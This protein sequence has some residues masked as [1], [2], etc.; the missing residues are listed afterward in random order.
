MNQST[1]A[2]LCAS[3]LG[4]ACSDPGSSSTSSGETGDGD[5]DS[6]G[7]CVPPDVEAPD[8]IPIDPTCLVDTPCV[9]DSN[10]PPGYTCNAALE[11]PACSK[12]YCG[13]AGSP[14]SAAA[15]CLSDL[16]CDGGLCNPCDVCGDQCS[17][18]FQTDPQ[19]CGC[20]DNPV[21]EVSEGV[22]ARV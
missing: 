7:E 19:H 4:L 1:L 9:E 17:V 5:G 16:Q 14:C 6:D 20:C 22:E 12:I 11:P 21:P 15:S 2:L 10:C 18:D 3:F 13:V 8:P